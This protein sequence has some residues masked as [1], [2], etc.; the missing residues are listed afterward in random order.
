MAILMPHMALLGFRL[1]FFNDSAFFN[2]G[3]AI[4]AKTAAALEQLAGFPQGLFGG[5]PA[6]ALH[7]RVPGGDSPTGIHGE[8]PVGHGVDNPVD[9]SYIPDLMDLVGHGNLSFKVGIALR[10]VTI[11]Y[12]LQQI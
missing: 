10:N 8:H 11:R 6:D 4:L 9:E 2:T 1:P 3:R 5:I 7:G 12:F